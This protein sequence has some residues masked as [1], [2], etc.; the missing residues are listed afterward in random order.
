MDLAD[1]R[2][3]R[4]AMKKNRLSNHLLQLQAWA[5]KGE[6]AAMIA[7]SHAYFSG[8][9]GLRRDY[10]AARHWFEKICHD[11]DHAGYGSHALGV[12]HY[13]GLGVTVDRRKAF[14]YFRRSALLGNRRS[15]WIVATM[16]SAG[17]GTLRKLVAAK[18][19]YRHCAKD[20]RTN[21]LLRLYFL[22]L[23]YTG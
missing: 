3:L 20:K 13:K 9:H 12:I 16:L 14:A 8:K 23:S 22:L 11:E 21:P 4:E 15:K 10:V 7:L 5:A 1:I 18:T 6:S 17:N 2:K 19:I